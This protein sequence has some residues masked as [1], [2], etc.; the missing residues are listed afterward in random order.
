M[1]I[2]CGSDSAWRQ[3]CSGG[4]LA[5]LELTRLLL[6]MAIQFKYVVTNLMG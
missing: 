6:G 1:G 3:L 2:I 4:G 5:K